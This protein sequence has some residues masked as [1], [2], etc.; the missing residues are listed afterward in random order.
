MMLSQLA[1]V[2]FDIEMPCLITSPTVIVFHLIVLSDIDDSSVVPYIAID[3]GTHLP[4]Q[5]I[6]FIKTPQA[7]RH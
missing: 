5:L 3:D 1:W 4:N 6:R 7:Y 2:S